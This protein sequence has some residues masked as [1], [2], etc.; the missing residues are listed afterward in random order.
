MELNSNDPNGALVKW[1]EIHFPYKH[2]LVQ[3]HHQSCMSMD[4]Y[5]LHPHMHTRIQHPIRV[6]DIWIATLWCHKL[7]SICLYDLP[8]ALLLL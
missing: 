5:L 2:H 7:R 1:T 3:Y 6:S 4:N 8:D